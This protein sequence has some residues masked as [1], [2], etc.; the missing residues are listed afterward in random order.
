MKKKDVIPISS[1]SLQRTI[2]FTVISILLLALMYYGWTEL[3]FE[4][5]INSTPESIPENCTITSNFENGN[6]GK[7]VENP[8]DT[9]TMEF[10]P[11]S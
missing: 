2:G 11:G 3:N 9:F 10:G 7:V 5:A 1:R 4:P 8:P 6:I